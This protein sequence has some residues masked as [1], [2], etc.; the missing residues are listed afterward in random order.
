MPSGIYDR[1]KYKNPPKSK[2]G[3]KGVLYT[4]TTMGRDRRRQLPKRPWKAYIRKN[5]WYLCLG[6]FATKE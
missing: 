4:P 2:S 3:L 5:G 6:Y 1:Q